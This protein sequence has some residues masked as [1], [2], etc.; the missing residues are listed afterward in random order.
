MIDDFYSKHQ[1]K[2]AIDERLSSKAFKEIL[3]RNKKKESGFE[4][5]VEHQRAL[6]TDM[7]R[8][9]LRFSSY[10]FGDDLFEKKVPSKLFH[11]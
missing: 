3:V 11:I 2:Q 7:H 4:F 5:N 1:I 10:I 6:L 8:I 9:K